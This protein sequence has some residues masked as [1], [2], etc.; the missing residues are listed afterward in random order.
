MTLSQRKASVVGMS[1][2]S[3]PLD[4][5]LGD[6]GENAAL[7]WVLPLLP[8]GDSGWWVRAM[9]LPWFPAGIRGVDFHRHDDAGHRFSLRLVTARRCGVQSHRE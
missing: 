2:S 6:I 4:R 9:I 1:D 3:A 5:T 7:D 8:A